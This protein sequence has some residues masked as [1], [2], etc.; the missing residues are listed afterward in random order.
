M[1]NTIFERDSRYIAGTYG[2][3]PVEIVRGEGS[4]AYGPDVDFAVADCGFSDIEGVLRDGYRNAG[5]PVFLVDLADLGTRMR[6]GFA[7][8]D[9]RPIDALDTNEVPILFI[10]GA[11]DNLISPANSERMHER[12]KVLR[13]LRFI[14]GAGHA[15]SAIVAPEEYRAALEGFLAQLG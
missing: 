1:D 11:A 14:A 3:F 8:K 12:T 2:R 13:S 6:Y 15:E 7:L 5:A 9:A 4:L 10:H